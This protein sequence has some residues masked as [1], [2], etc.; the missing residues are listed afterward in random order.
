MRDRRGDRN[1]HIA[2][3]NT[4]KQTRVER[5]SPFYAN[6]VRQC[7][8]QTDIDDRQR[9]IIHKHADDEVGQEKQSEKHQ[10]SALRNP[11]RNEPCRRTVDDAGLLER[12]I[13][14]GEHDH[15]DDRKM[16]H[17]AGPD[18]GRRHGTGKDEQREEQQRAPAR[19]HRQ[20]Q[21]QRR[22]GDREHTNAQHGQSVLRLHAKADQQPE[23]QRDRNVQIGFIL[24]HREKSSL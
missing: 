16:S 20:P 2:P 13:Q 23:D 4:D 24:I 9:Q 3:Q 14:N 15:G 8:R 10:R 11:A 22:N 6:L 17:R 7:N 1:D 5:I 12:V 19:V 18:L 21:I